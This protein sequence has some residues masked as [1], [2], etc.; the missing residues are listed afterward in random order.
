[1]GHVADVDGGAAHRLDREVVELREQSG[2]AL[3]TMGYS[4]SP[5]LAVPGGHDDVLGGEALFTSRG[6][7]PQA[8]SALRV[9]VDH[10][11]ALLAAV[12]VGDLRALDGGHVGADEV[13]AVVEE[14]LLAE[15]V[16]LQRH[17]EDGHA[18]GAVADDER[19]GGARRHARMAAWEM[20]VTWAVAASIFAPG[21]KKIFITETPVSDWLSMCSMSLTVVVRTRS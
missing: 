18:G 2:L 4:L 17:L 8:K 1:M 15:R 16:A 12:G 14:L 6:E 13:D 7:R 5:I 21:W 19:R 10:D 9:E 11:L 3:S 20:A